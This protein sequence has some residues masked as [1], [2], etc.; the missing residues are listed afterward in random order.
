LTPQLAT[1]FNR[2]DAGID[3]RLT[4]RDIF[5]ASPEN[6]TK[7]KPAK[8]ALLAVPLSFEANQGQTDSQVKFLSRGDGYSLA[9]SASWVFLVGRIEQVIWRSELRTRAVSP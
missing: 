5:G 2:F 8:A 1:D 3:A 7:A 9:G 4:A 6:P